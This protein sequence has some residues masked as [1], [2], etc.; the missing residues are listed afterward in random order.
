ML[1]K[2]LNALTKSSLLFFSN[3]NPALLLSKI[4]TGP[5]LQ[6]L[7]IKKVLQIADSMSTNPGSSQSE[8]EPRQDLPGEIRGGKSQTESHFQ[9]TF[10]KVE[11][12]WREE[13]QQ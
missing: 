5:F 13:E 1:K 8:S 9:I 4:S 3:N 10:H 12:G 2:F 7:L 6:L 11:G